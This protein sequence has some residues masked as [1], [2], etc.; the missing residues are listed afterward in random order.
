MSAV[1]WEFFFQVFYYF[2][3]SCFFVTRL[4]W[5]SSHA[6]NTTHRR[7]NGINDMQIN[8]QM[9][10]L[11]TDFR[12]SDSMQNQVFFTIIAMIYLGI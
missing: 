12:N 3:F 5:T 2:I 6:K 4:L 10:Y 7:L 9:Y 11:Q 8:K 1:Q